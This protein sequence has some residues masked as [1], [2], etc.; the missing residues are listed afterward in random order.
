[1]N[2]KQAQRVVMLAVC[3]LFFYAGN[4]QVKVGDNPT[5]INDASL[6]ELEST[7]QGLLPPR[8]T[9]TQR[10]AISNPPA[11]LTLF[12]TTTKCL[13]GFDGGFWIDGCGGAQEA[14]PNANLTAANV[15]YQGT[16]VINTTGIGYN[17]EAV[18][19]ASTITVEL[20]NTST[21]AQTYSL[22]ATDP[23]TGLSYTATGTIAG[24]ASGFSVVLNHN[25]V[26]MP[27]FS[28]GVITMALTGTSSTLSATYRC[29]VYSYQRP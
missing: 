10:D 25:E 15:T 14:A 26:V 1:M 17:G 13:Q 4:A 9:T 22:V 28:S 21:D 7:S 20:T 2:K 19:A 12:N 24:S 18:P 8:M 5:T 27:D 11:G 6:L 23:T 3:S 29:E 16:S